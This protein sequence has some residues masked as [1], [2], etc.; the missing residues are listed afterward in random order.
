M[1][2]QALK[3]FTDVHLTKF[4]MVLFLVS[5]AAIAI[6]TLRK[7]N[8]SHFAKMAELPLLKENNNE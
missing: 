7:S 2:Q 6:A 1:N 8:K 4:A 3:Y 5:F